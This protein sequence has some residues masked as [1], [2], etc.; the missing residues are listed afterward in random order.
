MPEPKSP[1]AAAPKSAAGGLIDPY[2]NYSYQI[3]ADSVI[4]H[5]TRL[6]GLGMRVKPIRYREGGRTNEVIQLMGPV[7]Y[8]EVKLS[9]GIVSSDQATVWEWLNNAQRSGRDRRQVLIQLKGADESDALTYVLNEAWICEWHGAAL[10]SLGKDFAVE[11][12]SL[13]YQSI[14]RQ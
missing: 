8:P 4:G 1:P 11:S 12:I 13:A 6:E 5:F 10:D 9:Y 14:T 2:R 3:I 7:E